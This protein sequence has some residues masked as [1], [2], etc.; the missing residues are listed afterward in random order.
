MKLSKRSVEQAGTT[1]SRYFL[2]DEELIGFGMRVE[3][4][5]RKTFICRYRSGGIRRQYTVGRFGTI[6]V[7]QARGEARRVLGSVSL[8]QDPSAA[9][10]AQR[11]VLLFRD[12]VA[13]FLEGHG[14]KL[15]PGSRKDYES[16]LVGHAVP[17]LGN[18]AVN[19][20][21]PADLNRLHL[22][23]ADRP[24]RANR[25]L[26]YVGSV[27]SWAQRNGLVDKGFNP[28]ADVQRFK[29]P[30]RERYLTSEEIKRLGEILRQAE[31]AGL[32]W[33]I[34]A[35]G[36][37]AKHVAKSN[38]A[39]IYPP[40]LTGAVRLLLLTGCRLREILNLRW[41]DVDLDRGFLW[42]PDSKTGR[43]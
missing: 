2:W 14:P 37:T 23:L 20:I 42:L 27:F 8:G 32:P 10:Q 19:A 13:A 33:E 30:S 38:R 34:K 25:V 7:D 3:A 5:G 1:G 39:E 21:A 31:T 17:A 22:K 43:R 11:S 18:L 12:L 15:K 9:K 29:E 24:Y 41:Q 35:V 40:H 28:A 36:S 4:S 26:S 6:T 16:A